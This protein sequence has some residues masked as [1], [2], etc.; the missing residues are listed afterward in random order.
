MSV[1]FTADR[2]E[3][4]AAAEDASRGCATGATIRILAGLRVECEGTQVVFTGTDITVAVEASCPAVMK[5]KAAKEPSAFV[6]MDARKLVS[7]LKTL[8]DGPVK[9]SATK[10]TVSLGQDGT[11]LR[12]DAGDAD[13]FP[14]NKSVVKADS[15]F[16]IRATDFLSVWKRIG[17]MYSGDQSR[18]V[19]TAVRVA[20]QEYRVVF[21]ATD[22]YRLAFDWTQAK[23]TAGTASALVPGETLELVARL[24]K[25]DPDGLIAFSLDSKNNVAAIDVAEIFI[26]TRTV[27]GQYPDVDRLIPDSFEGE[28]DLDAAA[29]VK[30]CRRIEKLKG[31]KTLMRL[32]LPVA[33]GKLRIYTMDG[34]TVDTDQEVSAPRSVG[35]HG[36]DIGLNP[37]FFGDAI[38]SM[39]GEFVTVKYIG[40]LRPILV[41]NGKVDA[42]VLQM[43][44]K[45]AQ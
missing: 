9:V 26:T 13:D 17:K 32:A 29:T 18:P 12:L 10:E 44:I 19:L 43:P 5:G 15:V 41:V 45:V 23:V 40:P 3:M 7:M 27:D 14:K 33:D 8:D 37:G 6:I 30:A 2:K 31:T 39:G 11:T 35:S 34:G 28:F 42:G 1:S 4:L 21:Q 22:S 38:E 24:A 36:F 25:R 20:S 16:E